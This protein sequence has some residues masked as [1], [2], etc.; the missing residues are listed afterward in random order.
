MA[1]TATT[2]DEYLDALSPE[3]RAE[4]ER[5]R[6]IVKRLVPEVDEKISYR[7]PTLAY[8][9][10]ALVYFTASKKHLSFYPSEWA[11]EEF[12]DRLVDYT[13]TKHAIQFTVTKPLPDDL[14]EDLVRYHAAQIDENRQQ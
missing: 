9:G 4:L 3:Y 10:R 1:A 5:I 2:I 8:K 14:I 12:A 13:T 7:M 6:S 11:I